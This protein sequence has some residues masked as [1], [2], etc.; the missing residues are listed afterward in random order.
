MERGAAPH[1]WK[2]RRG[3]PIRTP[4]GVTDSN[5]LPGSLAD[6]EQCDDVPGARFLLGQGLGFASA[7]TV[8]RSVFPGPAGPRAR[9]PDG[10]AQPVFPL[11]MDSPENPGFSR[12]PADPSAG[13][14]SARTVGRRE[15]GRR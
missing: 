13:H 15:A 2:E 8:D 12:M 7:W 5:G 14:H 9:L 1:G 11:L 6:P 4:G 3:A 10:S